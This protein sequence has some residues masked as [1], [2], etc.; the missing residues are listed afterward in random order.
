M[1][2]GLAAGGEAP[3]SPAGWVIFVPGFTGSKEDFIALPPELA[4]HGIGLLSYDQLG[5]YES[6]GSDRPQDHAL[7]QLAADLAEVIDQAAHRFGR[8]DPP[9]LVGHSFGGLVAQQAV[10]SRLV[11]PASLVL[12]CTGPGALPPR[13]RGPLPDMLQALPHASLAELWQV[14]LAL[15]AARLDPVDDGQMPSPVVMSFLEQRWLRNHPTQLEQFARILLEQE[16]MTAALA[17]VVRA[18]LPTTVVWGEHD[19]AWPIPIQQAMAAELG[20]ATIEIPGGGHSPNADAPAALV[21]ALV[22]AWGPGTP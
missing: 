3:A 7:P 8:S 20:A 14:K 16:P 15:D 22:R 19:D 17:D 6:D 4:A 18:G 13:R 5:Q 1:H 2:V 9:H 11:R 12:L 21:A 10:A